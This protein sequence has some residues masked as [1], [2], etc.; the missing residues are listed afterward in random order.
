[1]L[2]AG[3]AKAMVNFYDLEIVELAIVDN[4]DENRFYLHFQVRDDDHARG[5]YNEMIIA[6]RQ[7]E[8]RTKVKVLLTCSSALTTSYFARY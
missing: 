5:L 8:N 1:V 4:N 3:Y 6:L 2:D 7:L